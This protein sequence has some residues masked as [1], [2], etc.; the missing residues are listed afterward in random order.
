MPF[1]NL[2]ICSGVLPTT[3][4]QNETYT[5][6]WAENG[7]DVGI[8]VDPNVRITLAEIIEETSLIITAEEGFESYSWK[9][10]N[11][12]PDGVTEVTALDS[13]NILTITDFTSREPGTYVIQV[14]AIKN[15]L[16]YTGRVS[17]TLPLE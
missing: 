5:A 6:L 1:A 9:I 4:T 15:G 14:T 3:F 16:E 2:A 13:Q 7:I 10:D 12:L 17:K 11:R 8:D